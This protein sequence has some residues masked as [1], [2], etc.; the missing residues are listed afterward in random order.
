MMEGYRGCRDGK[1]RRVKVALSCAIVLGSVLGCSRSPVVEY[2]TL[3]PGVVAEQSKASVPQ[4]PT[5]QVVLPTLPAL[6]DRAEFTEIEAKNRVTV[7]E[8]VRWA[9][10]LRKII[11]DYFI[12]HLKQAIPQLDVISSATQVV[13]RDSH[14]L[15]IVFD[16]FDI[17]A[18]RYV[19]L[20]LSWRVSGEGGSA[21]QNRNEMSVQQNIEGD[22]TAHAIDAIRLALRAIAERVT[23]EMLAHYQP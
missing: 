21:R 1:A 18:G 6:V 17:Y 19:D 10:D 8:H 23:A 4:L 3:A 20:A 12:V 2:Y 15:V 13:V 7:H 22:E 16:R 14:K 11:R 9:V 5:I